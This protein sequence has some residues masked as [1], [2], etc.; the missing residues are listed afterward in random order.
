MKKIKILVFSFLFL[1]FCVPLSWASDVIAQRQT[2]F[3]SVTDFVSTVGKSPQE[4]QNIVRKRKE[5][6]KERRL[7]AMETGRNAHGQKKMKKQEAAMMK[8]INASK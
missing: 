6:R 3:N 1:S 4:A 7:Q 2:F 8:K 5:L